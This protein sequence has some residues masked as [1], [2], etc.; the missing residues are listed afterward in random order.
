MKSLPTSLF[1]FVFSMSSLFAQAPVGDCLGA[2]SVCQQVYEES[3][4]PSG[5]GNLLEINNTFNCMQVE[6]NSIWYTFTVNQSGNFG[7]VLTPNNSLDDYDWSLFD[8]TNA[9]CEDL[10]NDPELIVSC[11]AAGGTGC[12]GA[13]GA[14]GDTSFDNQGFNCNQNPPSTQD[15]FS[16]FNDLV[17]VVAGNT[18]VLCVSNWT[19]SPNGYTLDFGLSSGIGIFDEMPPTIESI[20]LPE[21]CQEDELIFVFSEFIQCETVDDLNFALT[22]IGGPFS[23]S[24]SSVNCDAGGNFAK[25]FKLTIDPPL[26][27]AGNYELE[28]IVDGSSEVLDLCDNPAGPETFAFSIIDFIVPVDLG[29][30]LTLCEGESLLLD[31]TAAEASYEWQDGS[32]NPMF[33]VTEAGTYWVQ[34]TNNC[35]TNI[36]SLVVDFQPSLPPI[37]LGN[38]TTLCPGTSLVLDA[39]LP[40][41]SYQWQDGSTNATFE[42]ETPGTYTVTIASACEEQTEEIQIDYFPGISASLQD[43]SLCRGETQVLNVS[44]PGASYL[45]QDGTTGPSI[46][47][48]EEGNYAVTITTICETAIQ[49]T[50]ITV[51]EGPPMLE[52][53]GDTSLCPGEV[54]LFDLSMPGATYQWQDGSNNPVYSI[55]SSGN[56]A[57]TVSNG[58]GEVSD[59]ISVEVFEPLV[60]NIGNDT[61]LCPGTNLVLDASHPSATFYRWH[62]NTQ[63]P[64]FTVKEPGMI[65]VELANDCESITAELEIKECEVCDVFVPN[66]FSPNDDGIND[67]FLPFS[68]CALEA[69]QL[70]IFDRWGSVLFESDDP[71]IGWDGRV[72]SEKIGIGVY[73]WMLDFTVVENNQPR[74]INLSGDILL[75][76]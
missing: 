16:P 69:F 56:Y 28:L 70:R 21:N 75:V 41:A 45:W 26:A 30:D 43:A 44:T 36:D 11:N 27:N 53:G 50:S 33:E 22:G 49:T 12:I 17:P 34:V 31:V 71:G 15:G 1:L 6:S 68:D 2:I 59:A 23:I 5:G 37:E 52:L 67:Q 20:E 73:V 8:I 74:V 55:A 76:R 54:L 64:T 62:D 13:T 40:N 10:F 48:E 18:Y 63:E 14:T 47:V 19:S 4:S 61:F 38:D 57:L 24:L 46:S 72:Q 25:E 29:P 42:V 32:T 7:F 9:N 39:T 51:E 35:G 65:S 60:V 58:C 66:A 3:E